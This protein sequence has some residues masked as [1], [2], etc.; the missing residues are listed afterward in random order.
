VPAPVFYFDLNSPY[1]Y[2]A[3][4][5]V[6]EVLPVRP[7][8]RPIAF[9]V[10]VQETGKVPWSFLKDERAAGIDEIE[11]RARERGLPPVRYPPGWPVESYSL[12]PLRA[13][14]LAANG[15]QARALVGELYRTVFVDGKA[16]SDVGAVLAAAERA[17][18]DPDEVRDGIARPEIKE[19]LR[20]NTDGALARGITGVPTVAV[21]EQ[22]FW[23]DDRLEEAAAALSHHLRRGSRAEG[24]NTALQ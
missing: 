5:R 9:G 6:D 14:L 8:W 1:A 3:S 18:M 4:A 23:G 16:L 19:R 7:E 15:D 22:L 13:V 20:A 17:G 12:T 11:R 24:Q 2:L 10:I 21:G